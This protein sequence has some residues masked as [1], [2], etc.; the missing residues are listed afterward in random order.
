MH[1]KKV[2]P[3]SNDQTL[4]LPSSPVSPA[5]KISCEILYFVFS[6]VEKYV[7]ILADGKRRPDRK[8]EPTGLSVSTAFTMSV[9][10]Y[11][12]VL[13]VVLAYVL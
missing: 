9:L 13:L 1:D 4:H 3:A 2:I 10:W 5:V 8:R 7:H 6:L 12:V 11:S